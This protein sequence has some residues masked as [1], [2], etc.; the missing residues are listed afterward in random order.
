[1]FTTC[2]CFWVGLRSK[3]KVCSTIRSSAIV[4]ILANNLDSSKV[5]LGHPAIIRILAISSKF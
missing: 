4:R 1:M 3:C 5:L 2:G